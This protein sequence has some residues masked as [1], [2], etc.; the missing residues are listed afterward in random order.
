MIVPILRDVTDTRAEN[1]S[2]PRAATPAPA[3]HG[4]FPRGPA[5]R[6][7]P[8]IRPRTAGIAA[9]LVLAL[10]AGVCW[11]V[12]AVRRQAEFEGYH[13]AAGG[14]YGGSEHQEHRAGS[15][16][17]LRFT[18]D[19]AVLHQIYFSIAN[20]GAHP[21]RIEELRQDPGTFSIV[22]VQISVAGEGKQPFHPVE[23][24]PGRSLFLVLTVR[25]E[26][27]PSPCSRTWTEAL[28]VRYTVLGV[29][30]WEQVPTT[31]VIGFEASG[32]DC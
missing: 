31:K 2:V 15:V 16:T 32:P 3:A 12:A 7:W 17:E 26:D 5:R 9:V 14:W 24:A 19:P 10:A 8:S 18:W 13:L 22:D 30:R 6:S 29:S 1:T 23:I 28:P 25:T 21:V 4:D 27:P 11:R 20:P